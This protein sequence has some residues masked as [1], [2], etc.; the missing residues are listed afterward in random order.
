MKSAVSCARQAETGKGVHMGLYQASTAYLHH[1]FPSSFTLVDLIDTQKS[2]GSFVLELPIW[3]KLL[4]K[5]SHNVFNEMFAYLKTSRPRF[6]RMWTSVKPLSTVCETVL[7]IVYIKSEYVDSAELWELV[8]Q[9]A[10]EWVQHHVPDES[11]R[12]TLRAMAQ[13]GLRNGSTGASDEKADGNKDSKT[14]GDDAISASQHA[15]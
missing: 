12:S 6:S 11:V 10:S 8:I 9:K 4:D 5:F 7:V 3:T 2:S 1:G 14:E 15:P 13:S